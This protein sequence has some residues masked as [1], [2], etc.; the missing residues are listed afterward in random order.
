MTDFASS[1][2]IFDVVDEQDRVVA[3][4]TRKE[5][6]SA[7]LR[8]RAVH[9][10]VF[11]PSGALFLQ[12]R[13]QSKDTAPGAWDSSTSGHVNTGESYDACAVRELEEEIGW[14]TTEPP[15]RWF[16]LPACDDTGQEF[17]WVYRLEAAG[18]FTL[19]AEEIERGGW[20]ATHEIAR[21]LRDHPEEFAPAFRLIWRKLAARGEVP[22]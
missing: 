3:R 16:R 15:P 11:N 13:A 8:H 12:K 4:A 9:V 20:M 2:E 6:H 19:N 18:P 1:E 14:R 22:L 7:G 17:V 5:V 10:L 21:R